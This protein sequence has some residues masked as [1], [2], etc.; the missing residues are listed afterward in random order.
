MKKSPWDANICH[1]VS[2]TLCN[3]KCEFAWKSL[4]GLWNQPFSQQD[5]VQICFKMPLWPLIADVFLVKHCVKKNAVLLERVVKDAVIC[6]L[7]LQYF[8]VNWT[9]N[10]CYNGCLLWD[11]YVLMKVAWMTLATCPEFKTP[12]EIEPADRKFL[13]FKRT[14]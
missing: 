9:K 10:T 13:H 4:F 2:Q 7:K 5:T 14:C 12:S 11:K 3:G 1:V 8:T 6:Q